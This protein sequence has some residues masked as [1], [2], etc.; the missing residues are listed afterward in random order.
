MWTFLTI[1]GAAWLWRRLPWGYLIVGGGLAGLAAALMVL[2]YDIYPQIGLQFGPPS[3]PMRVRIM[4]PTTGSFT[5]SRNSTVTRTPHTADPSAKSCE[6][7][8]AIVRT[9]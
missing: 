7:R 4:I 2:Q 1:V 6:Y 8:T 3:K 9:G 5:A